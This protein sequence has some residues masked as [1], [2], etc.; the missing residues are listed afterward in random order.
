MQLLN[1]GTMASRL[2]LIAPVLLAMWRVPTI[3]LTDDLKAL[4]K[5][6]QELSLIRPQ[7]AQAAAERALELAEKQ[8]GPNRA[9]VGEILANL[10]RLHMQQNRLAEA[11]QLFERAIATME[12]AFGADDPR[13]A[14]FLAGVGN[15][16]IRRNFAETDRLYARA[17]GIYERAWGPDDPRLRNKLFMLG[18]AYYGLHRYAQALP[19][20]EWSLALVEQA[21]DPLGFPNFFVNFL[22]D[23][24][25]NLRLLADT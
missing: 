14:D 6:A 1:R 18:Y 24:L 21:E 5:K 11:G 9:E 22:P 8:F 7:E 23:L 2:W 10:A 20:L 25:S 17:A 3:A 19:L 16:Y 4:K 13:F 12:K 15:V